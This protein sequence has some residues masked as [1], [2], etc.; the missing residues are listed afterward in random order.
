MNG[1]PVVEIGSR[2]THRIRDRATE[3]GSGGREGTSKC[4]DYCNCSRV[5][6]FDIYGTVLNG[7]VNVS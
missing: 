5:E 3:D 7:L 2:N 1:T 6:F 4:E